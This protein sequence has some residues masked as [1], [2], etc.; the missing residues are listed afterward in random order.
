MQICGHFKKIACAPLNTIRSCFS[1]LAELSVV[2]K[3]PAAGEKKLRSVRP[4]EEVL[5]N[6][7]SNEEILSR[8]FPGFIRTE[9][10]EKSEFVR[11][12]SPEI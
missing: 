12:S 7:C 4:L 1:Y 11:W 10:R 5:E 6:M 8:G 9:K 2:W 3:H